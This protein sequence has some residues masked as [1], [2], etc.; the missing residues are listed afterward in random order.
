MKLTTQQRNLL[1]G[2]DEDTVSRAIYLALERGDLSELEANDVW[3]CT[4]HLATQLGIFKRAFT[5]WQSAASEGKRLESECFAQKMADTL[6]HS[7][8]ETLYQLS[9]EVTEERLYIVDE[10][11]SSRRLGG[12]LE[13]TVKF[14]WRDSVFDDW[15]SGSIHFVYESNLKKAVERMNKGK[16][17]T[18][19]ELRRQIEEALDTELQSM[20][21]SA[22]QTVR[23]FFREGGTG[24]SIPEE[25]L[26][27]RSLHSDHLNNHSLNFKPLDH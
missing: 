27:Q 3:F 12:S 11:V 25:H 23:N 8:R 17:K 22:F 15:K 18:R 2:L 26:V 24:R 6:R 10:Y 20:E 9:Q 16:R 21:S 7:L 4:P 13:V 5:T 1:S 14:E 19:A